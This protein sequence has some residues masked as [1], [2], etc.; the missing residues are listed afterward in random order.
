MSRFES[1]Y[2][3]YS[4]S[5]AALDV[6]CDAKANDSCLRVLF[7]WTYV[8]SM[9]LFSLMMSSGLCAKASLKMR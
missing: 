2:L 1:S 5:I 8:L 9:R 3:R 4:L 6:V 7:Y